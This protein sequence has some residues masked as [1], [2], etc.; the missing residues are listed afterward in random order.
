VDKPRLEGAALRAVLGAVPALIVALPATYVVARAA[1]LASY[2]TL[3]RDQGI[4]QYIAWAMTQGDVDYRDVR[5]V[6]GPLIHGLHRLLFALGGA[7]EHRFRIL[8]LV[9]SFLV[10]GLAGA[11]VPGFV[12]KRAPSVLQRAS[13]GLLAAVVLGGQY[14]RYLAWD[15]A[16]RESMCDWFVLGAAAAFL[17][18]EARPRRSFVAGLLLGLAC[19]GKP[20][21]VVFALCGALQTLV[22]PGARKRNLLRYAMGAA[23]SG[24]LAL[25]YLASVGD[26]GAFV[27]IYLVDAPRMYAFIWPHTARELMELGWVAHPAKIG[28]AAAALG[29]LLAIVRVLP[30]RAWFVVAIPVCGLVSVYLQKKGFPYHLHPVTA[31]AALIGV[32]SFGALVDALRA[33]QGPASPRHR[34]R[35]VWAVVTVGLGV[36]L[37]VHEVAAMRGSPHLMNPWT[38]ELGA[39]AEGR[40]SKAYLDRFKMW[41]F[42]PYEMRETADYLRAHTA[43]D[44]RVQLYGMDPY[45]LFLA[46][47]RSASPYIYAYDLNTDAAFNGAMETLP[48]PKNEAAAAIIRDMGAAHARDLL[49]RLNARPPAA[50]VL[51]DHAPLSSYETGSE[52]LE[53]TQPEVFA[54]LAAHYREE[55][56]FGE[57]HVYLPRIAP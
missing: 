36:F 40:T 21:Y 56:K 30:R 8:D 18:E 26:V 15:L 34:L 24:A 5:D 27:R 42:F 54:Y 29:T 20:T 10:F 32:A 11:A 12:A 23:T 3:G 13:F 7:D 1:Y 41:D 22:L 57:I 6:N 47:R 38:A 39:T 55:A 25:V 16:Q 14:L 28:A 50:W 17:W 48:V 37:A 51:F 49:E 2:T 31:G 35:V 45:V 4:F 53:K 33:P 44:G 52:D 43:P 19:F 9:I 46:E